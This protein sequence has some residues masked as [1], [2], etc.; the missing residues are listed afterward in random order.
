MEVHKVV[1]PPHKSTVAKLKT[2][3]KETFFPDDPLR[4]FRG[5]PNR[6]KLIRA[7]QYIFPI[8]QWCPEYSFSLL[9]SDVVSGLTIASLAI[10]QGIS[11]AK[12]ANLPPIVGLYSSFVPPLV[13]AVLGSSRDLAVGPVSIASLI[14][15]SML[16][17]Q[18]SPVDD[19]VLFLQLAF[20]STFFADFL[21]KAT[22][23]GFMG[24]AAIIVSLQQLKGLLGITHFTKHMSVV[25]V[26]SSVFQ[27]TNEWSW[28]TIVMGVCF[29]LFLLSTRHLSMKKPKLFW[30]SAGAPLLSVIVS[31]LLV[32]V[33]RAERHGI[34]VIGKLPE[35]LNPP[36]WNMLQFHGSHLALVAKTGLV[37]GI[38]SLTEGIAVGRTFAALKNYHVDGNKEMIAIGL[39]NVVGS[40]T[41]CYVTTGAF[42]RSAVNNNAGAKTAVSNIVMSVTVMVTLLFLMPLFEYTPNVVLG[43]IIVT[44]VIGLIDL[45]AACHIWKIDKFDFLVMLCAFFGVIFL[46]VQNGLAIAVGLSL[47]KILM[48]VTRP[49]M[50]IM[51]NIPGTDIYRDLHH[52][53]EAQRIPGFLVL[54]I[55]SPVNFANSNYLTERTSRWIEECEEEEA[56]EK[57]SS[58][59]FLILEMSAVSGV[60]T[61][62]VSFFKE[63]K[64]T[65]AKKDI[66]LVFVN[67]LSEVVEKLQRADEQKEFMRPEFLFLTVAEA[68]ASLSL[69]GPSLS[70]V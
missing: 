32:F 21:S 13:Y 54:S 30:V 57:H 40:A 70:N 67:P 62:G 11:Y 46:S 49:K 7:A 4:Q 5:Q 66:E 12:L 48:Q 6:T 64:K 61:N 50:V 45:P 16:R 19:P 35:G 51:G 17:Q 42:S 8:L 56:Q 29:L 52:Y 53:K 34:S 69:K 65:T 33:F 31:T 39:M 43:A 38:V 44:A 55:E 23:I 24:G 2:K 14:L 18:V 36:S 47:F 1:A 27:H 63:L 60:D 15:G 26:L 22:L 41:S 10:P 68:V 3:L 59:Q 37:T 25:P 9:K 28:Q 20:S 58:L